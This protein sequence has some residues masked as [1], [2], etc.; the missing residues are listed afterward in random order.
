VIAALPPIRVE[1]PYKPRNW[2]RPAH[3]TFKRWLALVLHRRAGKTTFEL[4]H[5]QRA[6]TDDNWERKRLR[7]LLP[8]APVSQIETL[9]KKRIYWHVMPS[10]KQAKLVAWE[11]LKDIARP[12]PGHKFNESELL[13]VYPNGN[14]V[15]LIGGDNPDSL[16]GPALSG[17]SL[18][19][20]SQIPANVFGEILSK[21]LAD[22]VGYCIWSGTIKGHDQLYKLY[23]AACLNPEWFALWQDV[24]VSLANEEGAT[25]T[26]LNRAMSDDRGLVADGVMT[27][28]EYDQEWY[29]SPDAAIQGAWYRK[30]MATAK[31]QGRITRVP[32]EPMLPVNT[33]WDLGMD[34]STAIIFSQSFRSGEIRVIDYY[35]ASGEGFAHYVKALNGTLEGC[36]HRREYVYGKHHPPHDIAVR[37]LGTGKSRKETAASLGL[38]FEEPLPA[39]EVKD[40]IDATRLLLS[41]CWFDETRCARLIEALRNYRKA[42]NTRLAEFTGTPVHNW[43]SHGSD[44]LRGLAV[45]YQPPGET[46]RPFMYEPQLADST[47]TGWMGR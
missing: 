7:Y 29:L 9:L 37:E 12:I 39:L 23:Q 32:Y 45:R 25:I 44:A 34:D 24:D 36:E 16:R 15:Q 5:H 13:V 46:R 22:H 38:T 21:A 10:Y 33:D 30:E 31:A 6:A 2:A 27:Q 11:M 17:L 14:R 8:D 41:K 18:D 20:F 4:N 42:F 35:E 47:G 28:D 19:E 43:A 1:I 40:G 26:A 3:A